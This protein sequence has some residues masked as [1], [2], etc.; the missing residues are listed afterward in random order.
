MDKVNNYNKYWKNWNVLQTPKIDL[1]KL[2]QSEEWEVY[3]SNLK[4]ICTVAKSGDLT[5]K[6]TYSYTGGINH[7]DI[8]K[9]DKKIYNQ[10]FS[11]LLKPSVDEIKKILK[12]LGLDFDIYYTAC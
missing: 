6:I 9:G 12:L 7:I 3:D 1:D 8:I 4:D 5:L 2:S 10:T 11:F